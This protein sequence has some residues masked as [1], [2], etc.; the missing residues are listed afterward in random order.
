M[1]NL[2][3]FISLSLL[4][5]SSCR[6]LPA[7]SPEEPEKDSLQGAWTIEFGYK[8]DGS[9]DPNTSRYALLE[10]EYSDGFILKDNALCDVVWSGQINAKDLSWSYQEEKLTINGY[11]FIV[12]ELQED[13]MDF[14]TPKGYKYHLIKK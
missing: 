10:F 5:F 1:K 8:P 13:Q 11:V 4:I 9:V 6:P 14:E 7:P 3:F 2:L 12:S